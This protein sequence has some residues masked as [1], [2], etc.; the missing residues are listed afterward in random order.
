MHHCIFPV[1]V[2]VW[3]L[4]LL[5]LF[6]SLLLLLLLS[7]SCLGE[8]HLYIVVYV[9]CIS[10]WYGCFLKGW[11]PQNT[12]KWSV[13]VGEAHGCWVPPH[14]IHRLFGPLWH[15]FFSVFVMPVTH[16]NLFAG[17][18]FG[19]NWASGTLVHARTVYFCWW[20][21]CIFATSQIWSYMYMLYRYTYT[22]NALLNVNI[23]RWCLNCTMILNWRW[24]MHSLQTKILRKCCPCRW[25]T[26]KI[27]GFQ[28]LWYT[29][30]WDV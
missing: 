20:Q 19:W 2:G 25:E 22:Y 6:L 8:R 13:L 7:S 5:L 23:W 3:L 21:N 9:A 24:C 30:C 29:T 26:F 10:Y 28:R 15:P 27:G 16:P 12:P 17:S 1:I 4:V 18:I 11:Y 14:M